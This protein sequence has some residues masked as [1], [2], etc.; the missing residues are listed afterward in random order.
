MM[1]IKK[2][3]E[4]K[5]LVMI[6]KVRFCCQMTDDVGRLK[7]GKKKCSHILNTIVVISLIPYWM[8]NKEHAYTFKKITSILE[9]YSPEPRVSFFR[10]AESVIKLRCET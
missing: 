7:S 1:P 4:R 6:Y 8:S 3:G 2:S 10:K 9:N 5:H